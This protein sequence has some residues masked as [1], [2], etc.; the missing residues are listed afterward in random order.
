MADEQAAGCRL[1]GCP[2]VRAMAA[3]SGHSPARAMAAKSGHKAKKW[4]YAKFH[5]ACTNILSTNI[6]YGM[7][8][9][10]WHTHGATIWSRATR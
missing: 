5:K 6:L 10:L 7:G 1:L 9:R 8:I 4:Q 2:S 3:K